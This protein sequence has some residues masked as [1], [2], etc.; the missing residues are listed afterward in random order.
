MSELEESFLNL[1]ITGETEMTGK[2]LAGSFGFSKFRVSPLLCRHPPP[3]TGKDSD[4]SNIKEILD[5]VLL[6]L[7]YLTN[8]TRCVNR[9]LCGADN[10]IGNC[11]L[12]LMSINDRYNCFLPEFPLLHLRKSMITILFSSYKDAGL[13][14]LI[15]YMRDDNRAEWSRL[16][17]TH[18]IDAA[19]RTVKRIGQAL[20]LAFLVAF[21]KHLPVPESEIFLSDMSSLMPQEIAQKWSECLLRFIS[22][23]S[24]RN[25]TFALHRDM[26][27][28]CDDIV[29]VSFAERLGGRQGYQLLLAAVKSSLPFSFVNGASSYGPYCVQLLCQHYSA[30]YFHE[31]LKET[32]YTTPIGNSTKNFACD[33]KREMDHLEALK[34]FRSGSTMH[35][36]TCKMSLIDTLNEGSRIRP[37]PSCL[38]VDDDNL[39]W[40]LTEVDLH[41]IYPTAS[42]ILRRNA[43]SFIEQAAPFNVYAKEP[44]A[45]PTAILDVNSQQ[46][47]EFLIRKYC[48][49]EKLF[50]GLE[51]DDLKKEDI[52]GPT[53]L[54]QRAKK[55]KGT[56][57]KRTLKSKISVLKTMKEEKEEKRKKL[58]AKKTKEID[59]LT[60]QVNACQAL[61]KPDAS[62]PKVFKSLGMQ[63]AIK[64]QVISCIRSLN[65]TRDGSDSNIDSYLLLNVPH[66]PVEVG[67]QVT[68]ATMEFAGV[69]FKTAHCTSGKQYILFA[70]TVIKKSLRDFPCISEMVVCEEKYSYTPDDFKSA[71]RVQRQTKAAA[72]VEHLKPASSILNDTTFHKDALLKTPGGKS[73]ISKYLAENIDK[74][75]ISKNIR[76]I[77]DSEFLL[78]CSGCEGACICSKAAVPIQKDFQEHESARGFTKLLGVKQRK[79][80]AEMSQ[81]DWLVQNAYKV[82]PGKAAVS[83]VSSGD[84]DAVY[85][86]L[87]ALSRNWPRTED[88]NFLSTVY[89]ALQ[90]PGSK[91]DVYNITRILGLFERVYKDKNIGLKV[92]IGLCIGGNDFIP[93][94]QQIS[95]TTLM[96]LWLKQAYRSSCLTVSDGKLTLNED[97]FVDFIKELYCPKRICSEDFS[98]EQVRALS[99]GKKASD[100]PSG[101]SMKDPKRWL[102]PESAIRRLA[103]IVQLQIDYLLTAGVHEKELP[104]FLSK[105]CFKKQDGDI[106]FDFG[107]DAHFVSI[108][109]LPVVEAFSSRSK[110]TNEDTPQAGARRKRPLT[111]TPVK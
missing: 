18:H 89:V 53:D 100:S 21:A 105:S 80:E 103:E 75:S 29:A 84:I 13:V 58:V 70:E 61:L 7:G 85:I 95:H 82:L 99:I 34:G 59:C 6:K 51:C 64:D 36:I 15:K 2:E 48:V 93:K 65:V 25:A 66:I 71:T 44:T 39:G 52:F 102:P 97:K 101:Y 88:G 11:L 46:V 16:I 67:S 20:H 110:R 23:G 41:H 86:H 43:L 107:E 76:L 45:L 26:M 92:A 69:K 14:H 79:G 30:G 87:F 90:K 81:V 72:S 106:E 47:A 42:L 33:T 4:V 109:R 17:S 104:D 57:L 91:Y 77:I 3:A 50:A 49:K 12:K 62:K 74:L 27:K 31:K 37:E 28:H 63:K 40:S 73:L 68:F 96:K 54:V 35:S 10:K 55:A 78:E 38:E 108:D 5:D 24:E 94:F 32:L 9:I 1:S 111:S 83:I 8:K 98:F 22:E 60:S 56:T 19:T